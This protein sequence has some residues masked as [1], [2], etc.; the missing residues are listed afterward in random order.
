VAFAVN[1]TR[2]RG[3]RNPF[4]DVLR[5]FCDSA[6][7]FGSPLGVVLDGQSV[8]P[9]RRQSLAT[10]LGFSETVFVDDSDT[11]RVRIFTPAAELPSPG[12]PS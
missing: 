7:R 3:A 12:I 2:E 5:V 9:E 10:E 6:G 8:Q 4:L 1:L 11:G